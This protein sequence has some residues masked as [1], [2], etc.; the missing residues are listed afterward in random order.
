MPTTFVFVHGGFGSPAELAPAVP[1]LEARGHRVI[2]VDLPSTR[3]DATLE[4]YADAV[5]RAMEGVSGPRVFVAHSAGG[6]TIPLAAARMPVDRLVFAAA[7]VPQPGEP[8]A[9]AIGP[10]AREAIMAVSVDNGDGTRSFDFDLLASLAPPEQRAAY[11]A[12]L[13]ATQ[14]DQGWRAIE[15]PWPG[16]G[17]PD[18]PRSYILCTEDQIIPPER[19]RAFA[20]SLGV[21][22]IEIASEHSVFA[23]K[24]E[25]LAGILA[26]LVT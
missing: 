24:P 22:P 17:I 19:Q 1:H 6:A 11:L 5:C 16:T 25:E 9:E 18:I 15:Q 13:R 10:A 3:A 12:F 14:R 2:N 26:S 23:M 21:T 4:D 8:I 20:A 7:I